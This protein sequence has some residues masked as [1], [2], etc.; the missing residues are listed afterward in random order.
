ML[1]EKLSSNVCSLVPSEER[2]TFSVIF[3]MTKRGR[4]VGSEIC[5]SIIKSNRR[6]TYKEA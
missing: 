3:E 2:L 1:P 5:R 4:V 6:F